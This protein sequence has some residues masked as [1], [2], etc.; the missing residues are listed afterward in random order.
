MDW[1]VVD[2]LPSKVVVQG[3]HWVASIPLAEAQVDH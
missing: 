2:W 3:D 1:T